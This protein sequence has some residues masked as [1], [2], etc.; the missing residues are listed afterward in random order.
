LW[1]RTCAQGTANGKSRGNAR[2]L[3][4]ACPRLRSS[5]DADAFPE[6]FERSPTARKATFGAFCDPGNAAPQQRIEAYQRRTISLRYGNPA[7]DLKAIR[8]AGE[9]LT[10]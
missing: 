3:V 5:L 7:L 1:N 10:Q 4:R 2:D 8:E 9:R 6:N